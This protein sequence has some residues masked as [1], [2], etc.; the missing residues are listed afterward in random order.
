MRIM[1]SSE[2]LGQPPGKS[3]CRW[4]FCTMAWP[5]TS[6]ISG[7]S[8]R[9]RC[10]SSAVDLLR[11]KQVT[12]VMLGQPDRLTILSFSQPRSTFQTSPSV[13][14]VHRRRLRSRRSEHVFS[15]AWHVNSPARR[16]RAVRAS[17]TEALRPPAR[18]R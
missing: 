13:T 9:L 2:M 15:N 16:A 6:V 11:D 4:R 17:G 3:T 8:L 7:Q 14:L 5:I 18:H 12:S 1:G 10:L